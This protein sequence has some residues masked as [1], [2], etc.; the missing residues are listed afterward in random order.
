LSWVVYQLLGI[1]ELNAPYDYRKKQFSNTL[2][3][4]CIS[5]IDNM[6]LLIILTKKCHNQFII[7]IFGLLEKE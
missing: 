7:P 4:M 6:R 2:K 3:Y 5:N 1:V